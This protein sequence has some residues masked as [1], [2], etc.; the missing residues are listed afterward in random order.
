MKR[1]APAL[2]LA[3]AAFAPAAA[4]ACGEKKPETAMTTPATGYQSLNVA[5]LT[6]LRLQHP[7]LVLLDA[8]SAETRSRYGM[9]PGA[10]ALSSFESYDLTKELPADKEAMVV[11]YCA[12][13]K[14]SAAP[15]AATRAIL[16]GHLRVYVLNDGI[17][18]WR[19]AGQPTTSTRT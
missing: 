18:G 15:A 6:A 7:R 13:A 2:L 10:T 1:F 17:M 8:N 14:C 3:L 16:A 5:E 9:I 12:N 19:A 11:F 4:L